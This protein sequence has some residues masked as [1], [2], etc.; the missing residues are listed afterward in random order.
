MTSEIGKW[1]SIYR[2]RPLEL[3]RKA[4]KDDEGAWIC[5]SCLHEVPEDLVLPRRFADDPWHPIK[6]PKILTGYESLCCGHSTER[7]HGKH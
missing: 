6:N 3:Q 4:I 7:P 1:R 5:L 2:H